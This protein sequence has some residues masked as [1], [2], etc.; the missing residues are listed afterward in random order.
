MRP[1][2][3][4]THAIIDAH[5][6]GKINAGETFYVMTKEDL[7][8]INGEIVPKYTI[9]RRIEDVRYKPSYDVFWY[10]CSRRNAEYLRNIWL[11]QDNNI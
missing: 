10:F 7:V 4:F 5:D 2:K 8:S 6:G 9:T 11:I 1:F 3:F